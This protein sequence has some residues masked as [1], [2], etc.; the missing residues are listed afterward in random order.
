MDAAL[1]FPIHRAK[2]GEITAAGHLSPRTR[3]RVRPMFDVQ[4]HKP[5]SRKSIEVYLSDL[6]DEL[7]GSWGTKYPVSV[8]FSRYEP[9][10]TVTDG[11]HCAEYLF[12]CLRQRAMLG[13][14]VTGPE[15]LRGPGIAYLEAVGR[16]AREDRR[17]AGLRIPYDEV[18]DTDKLKFA[19]DTSLATLRLPP[20]DVDLYLDLEALAFAHDDSRTF[21]KLFPELVEAV[22]TVNDLGFRNVIIAGSSVPENVGKEYDW[23]AF[24]APRIEFEIWR[25]LSGESTLPLVGF[26]DYGV[27]YPKEQDSDKPVDPP[28]RIRLSTA[29]E[30]VF[31][32]APRRDY[33]DLCTKVASSSEF[34]VTLPAWGVSVITQCARYGRYEGG[35]TEWVA[36]DTNYHVELT[37]RE[38]EKTLHNDPRLHQLQF[39]EAEAFPWVQMTIE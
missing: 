13:I 10:A 37:L 22:L 38:I 36:R 6:A 33:I 15:S 5:N 26:G 23:S 31:W 39:A 21:A 17:G 1:Y 29:S 8:D 35:P 20:G 9:D 24:R 27:T 32:R 16:I 4:R 14:P 25:A 18:I 3:A 11:R 34:D 12:E 7:T 28:G 30:H 19:V 2:R